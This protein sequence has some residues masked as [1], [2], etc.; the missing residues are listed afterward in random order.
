MP[1][2]KI[3]RPEEAE[4]ELKEVYRKLAAQRAGE[5]INQAREATTTRPP[6]RPCCTA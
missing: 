5:A 2:I 4:G 6:R 1:W 3:I